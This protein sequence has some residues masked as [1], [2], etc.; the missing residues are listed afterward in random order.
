MLRLTTVAITVL[1]FVVVSTAP[2]E[3]RL[4]E[5]QA[6]HTPVPGTGG[7]VGLVTSEAGERLSH[8]LLSLSGTA[9]TSVA[10]SD[11][12]GRFKFQ[13]LDEGQYLLRSHHED[14]VSL[15]YIVEVQRGLT[16]FH[17]VTLVFDELRSSP[18]LSLTA[19]GIVPV[20]SLSGAEVFAQGLDLGL[21]ESI[22]VADPAA[23]EESNSS[24]AGPHDH[25]SKAWFL[26]RVQRSVLK[27]YSWASTWT[28]DTTT[29]E[30]PSANRSSTSASR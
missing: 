23:A 6:D 24:N 27:D 15:S 10:Q 13:K 30:W 28:A 7:I 17:Y 25:S 14:L 20:V 3:S 16:S 18:S 11:V 5:E 19:A 1:F 8:I 29:E 2:V 26:R 21:E 22:D 12:S 9:G 4:I